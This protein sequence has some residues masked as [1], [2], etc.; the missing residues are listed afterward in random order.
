M[1]RGTQRKT[2]VLHRMLAGV[3]GFIAKIIVE[4]AMGDV[5]EFL[6][7]VELLAIVLVPDLLL[8]MISLI[9]LAPLRSLFSL[10]VVLVPGHIAILFCG[11]LSFVAA[12]VISRAHSILY[13]GVE[14]GGRLS[15]YRVRVLLATGLFFV[16]WSLVRG[17][18]WYQAI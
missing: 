5:S 8:C 12:F 9:G 2:V 13:P 15:S 7:I 1:G 4:T 16:L 3:I 18:V 10:P 11:C 17:I 6:G 14:V